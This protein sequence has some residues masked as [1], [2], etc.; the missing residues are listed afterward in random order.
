V[1]EI[2]KTTRLV[3]DVEEGAF[4]LAMLEEAEMIVDGSRFSYMAWCGGSGLA[5]A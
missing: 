2:T 4:K 1:R 5:T 3:E